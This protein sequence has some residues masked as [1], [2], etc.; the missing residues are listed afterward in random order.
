[1]GISDVVA[2]LHEKLIETAIDPTAYRTF[3][4]NKSTAWEAWRMHGNKKTLRDIHQP[5][6]NYCSQFLTSRLKNKGNEKCLRGPKQ[7]EKNESWM[8]KLP[9]CIFTRDISEFFDLIFPFKLTD[10]YR[11]LFWFI[12]PWLRM[13]IDFLTVKMQAISFCSAFMFYSPHGIIMMACFKIK[14]QILPF[15]CRLQKNGR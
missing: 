15:Y 7:N 5:A 11:V 6:T 10:I 2:T 3:F 8:K 14:Y 13:V 1:M 4:Y 12:M 9:E